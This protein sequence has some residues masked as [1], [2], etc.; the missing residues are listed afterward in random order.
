MIACIQMRS[1]FIYPVAGQL[2]EFVFEIQE[3]EDT[4]FLPE[5]VPV[6]PGVYLSI[7]AGPAT[8][9]LRIDFKVAMPLLPFA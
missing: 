4:A 1:D 5:I 6:S 8:A 9:Y 7:M 3:A 2:G